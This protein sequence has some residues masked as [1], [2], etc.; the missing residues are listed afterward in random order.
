M[1]AMHVV[2][3]IIEALG[4]PSA[5]AEK[6]GLPQQTVSSWGTRKPPEIPP[7]HRPV[8]LGALHREPEPMPEGAA[9]YLASRQ[10]TRRSGAEQQ[11]A[12]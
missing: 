8:V 1:N 2:Q 4:G 5:A 7:W 9:D 11:A 12:A 3:A 6:T 10:R